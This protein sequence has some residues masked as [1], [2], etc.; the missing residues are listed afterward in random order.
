MLALTIQTPYYILSN[1]IKSFITDIQI[2]YW[3]SYYYRQ[4][5]PL[6]T[7][8]QL[9][10]T[11]ILHSFLHLHRNHTNIT[12]VTTPTSQQQHL[13]QW[14]IP[15]PLVFDTT[16]SQLQ[17]T[18]TKNINQ[19]NNNNNSSSLV[20]IIGQ[21]MAVDYLRHA[22]Y[23][24]IQQQQQQQSANTQETKTK[25][26]LIVFATGYEH[27]GKRT[28]AQYVTSHY[29]IGASCDTPSQ[30]TLYLHGY[31]WKL[32]NYEIDMEH[33]EHTARYRRRLYRKLIHVIESHYYNNIQR[34]RRRH[35]Y[36]YHDATSTTT[37][38]SPPNMIIIT[39]I[40]H[41]DSVVLLQLLSALQPKTQ[42][43][44]R[45]FDPNDE[46]IRIVDHNDDS[47]VPIDPSI[48]DKLRQ[49]CQNSVIYLTSNQYGV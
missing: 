15:L 26:P 18:H 3:D 11:S 22:M 31:D 7:T 25:R 24:W 10:F 2:L 40:E 28:L 48:H 32:Q 35:Y 8:I 45:N 47:N 29:R 33:P 13:C 39:N 17:Q 49:L 30:S 37:T 27:T 1:V 36:D 34:H 4:Q 46:H 16:E 43:T 5:Y 9:Y 23:T 6:F 14:S 20:T 44:I 21:E 42:D 12:T 19:H 38:D 41:M